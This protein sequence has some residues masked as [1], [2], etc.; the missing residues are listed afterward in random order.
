MRRMSELFGR[1]PWLWVVLGLVV[2]VGLDLVFLAVALAH[3]P[4]PLP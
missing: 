3:P 2:F 1:H 4:S